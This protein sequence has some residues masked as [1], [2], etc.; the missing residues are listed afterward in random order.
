[1]VEG[2]NKSRLSLT[3]YPHQEGHTS[4]ARKTK[5][6]ESFIDKTKFASRYKRDFQQTTRHN[7]DVTF[8]CK[9]GTNAPLRS[10]LKATC[11]TYH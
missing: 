4:N 1:M 9:G 10:K 3:F 11:L 2:A 7:K 5:V 8:I 6:E